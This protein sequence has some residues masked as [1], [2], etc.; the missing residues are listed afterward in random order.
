M[1]G[2]R[3]VARKAGGTLAPVSEPFRN[4]LRVRWAECDPQGVVFNPQYLSYLDTTITELWRSIYPGG[5]PG[6]LESGADMVLAEANLRFRGS[7]RFDDEIDVE[8]VVARLGK[9]A[10]S[11]AMTVVR[12]SETLLEADL[13]HV[14]VATGGGGKIPIP[15]AVRSA[16]SPFLS[17]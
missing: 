17:P 14:F 2:A 5:Y 8:V 13:R 11:T 15:D 1:A 6:M 10:M 7:A 3:P 16:L 4:R 9:T 12:G